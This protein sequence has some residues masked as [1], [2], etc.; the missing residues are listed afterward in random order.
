MTQ[1]KGPIVVAFVLGGLLGG[2]S[3]ALISASYT[4]NLWKGAAAERGCAQYD[5]KTGIWEWKK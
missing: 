5:V 4:A 3:L 2:F 1:M